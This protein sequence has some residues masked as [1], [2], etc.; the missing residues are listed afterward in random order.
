MKIVI[1]GG[2][3]VGGAIA[4]QLTREGH[5]I[6]VIDRDP[7]VVDQISETLDCMA[8]CGRGAGL[9]VMRSAGVP[10]SDLLIACTAEDELNMLCCAFAKK[11]GCGSAI[12][13]VRDPEY[14]AQIYYFKD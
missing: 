3:K 8:I 1:I 7:E 5:S 14:A 10:D 11:L 6:T 2:G 4:A 9:E 12:A 13:R